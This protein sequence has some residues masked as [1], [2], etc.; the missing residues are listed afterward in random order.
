MSRKTKPED[1]ATKNAH[2]AIAFISNHPIFSPLAARAHISRQEDNPYPPN[3][4]AIVT[5]NGRIYLHPKRRGETS[6]WIYVLAHCLLHLGLGHFK[7]KQQERQHYWN[8]ACDVYVARFLHDLKIGTPPADME[9]RFELPVKDEQQL[10]TYLL[11]RGL[12][13]SLNFAGTAGPSASDM[14]YTEKKTS[15]YYYDKDPDWEAY[16]AKGLANAVTKAVSVAG[17]HLDSITSESASLTAAVRAKRWFIDH[18]PLLGALA[19]GFK[20][21]EDAQI[22]QRL[23]ISIAAINILDRIIYMNPAAGLTD[24]E[25]LFVMA[26][27]L[28][29]AG[30]QHHE[31]CMGRDHYLWNIACDY[32]INLWLVEMKIGEYP[33]VGLMLDP[34]LRGLN[35]ESIYDRMVA[36]IRVYRKLAT[37]RGNGLGDILDQGSSGLRDNREGQSL[38]DFCRNAMQQGLIYHEEQSRGYLP[39]GLVEEIRALGQPPIKWDVELA[40]WFDQYFTPLEK[41]RTY[42]RVSRRQSST[43]DIPRPQ[44]VDSGS[45]EDGRTFGVILDTSGSM[46]K[47]LLAK[48][49]GAIA[50]YAA[51]R[52]VPLARI[53]FCDAAPYDAGYMSPDLI[54]DRVQVKGRGGTILQPAIDLLEHAEDFPKNGPILI[55]TDG[56]CDRLRIKRDHAYLL[57]KGKHLP[58]YPKGPVFRID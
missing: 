23:D 13:P 58:F 8:A 18:Y 57:P 27:E 15:F 14:D 47:K 2:A 29:H 33:R 20:I 25:T 51:A 41:K 30:L 44:W 43:P 22:C 54:S 17:G 56:E 49:L 55:I 31:R 9:T 10:Y 6:E 40:R 1:P 28:L 52:D 32:V 3:G 26:H 45:A 38:D 19:A 11:E 37:L 48:C 46:D 5:H 39:S 36:D 7:V 24:D 50:S 12:P 42:S 53:I 21:V 35:A 34:E 4:W 16:L